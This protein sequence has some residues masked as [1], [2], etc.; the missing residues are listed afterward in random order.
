MS[1]RLVSGECSFVGRNMVKLEA[2]RESWDIGNKGGDD[3]MNVFFIVMHCIHSRKAPNTGK[4]PPTNFLDINEAMTDLV[5]YKPALKVQC[6][7]P[8][9]LNYKYHSMNYIN[10]TVGC[11]AKIPMKEGRRLMYSATLVRVE[12]SNLSL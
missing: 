6:D 9:G 3:L 4:E 11:A 5:G 7:Q 1:L 8:V 2:P 12:V 10:A